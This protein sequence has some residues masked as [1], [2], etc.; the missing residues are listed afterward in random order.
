[1]H[2][3]SDETEVIWELLRKH[4]PEVTLGV[5]KVLGIAREPG[6]RSV[7][8]VSS[9]DPRSD[10]VGTCVGLRGARVKSILSELGGGEMIDVVRWDESPERFITNT[11][12]P[13]RIIRAS[14]EDAT[15]EA[16]VTV[17]LPRAS[18]LPDLDLRSKLVMSL[19]GWRLH[20]EVKHED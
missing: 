5:I 6:K 12:I 16:R 3:D 11:L 18:R 2:S 7:L 1:M 15:R 19:T 17:V 10:P 9:S 14:Y 8:A 13:L 20:L 4:V